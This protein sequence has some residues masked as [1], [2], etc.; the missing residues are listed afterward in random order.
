MSHNVRI[1]D[2]LWPILAA[3]AKRR[4]T[5]ASRLVDLAVRRDLGLEDVVRIT[6]EA[7]APVAEEAPH[8]PEL[9]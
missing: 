1:K 5:T 2:T 7:P 3:E 8:G 6:R 4:V 9:L